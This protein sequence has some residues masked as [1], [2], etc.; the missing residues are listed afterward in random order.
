MD[1]EYGFGSFNIVIIIAFLLPTL[2]LYC[3]KHLRF[4]VKWNEFIENKNNIKI[5]IFLLVLWITSLIIIENYGLKDINSLFAR[6]EFD[7][8]GYVYAF[9]NKNNDKSYRLKANMEKY[10]NDF[11]VSK[12]YFY[13]GGSITFDIDYGYEMS[14]DKKGRMAC[15]YHENE[16]KEWCFRFYGEQIKNIWDEVKENTR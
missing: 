7:F 10:G 1:Y 4:N 16:D 15:Q 8:M 13:N 2:L 3:I 14:L 11:Y 9:P 6:K 5:S 12:I